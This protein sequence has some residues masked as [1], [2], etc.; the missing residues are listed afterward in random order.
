MDRQSLRQAV[1]KALTDDVRR[2]AQDIGRKLQIEDGNER[3]VA[4]LI[5]ALTPAQA[6]REP[7]AAAITG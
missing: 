5:S 4:A 7:D 3:A 6:G 2:R 1:Q